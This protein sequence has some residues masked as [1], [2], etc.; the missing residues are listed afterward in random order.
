M[1]KTIM[2][3]GTVSGAGK[4]LVASGL[5]R[6]FRQDGYDAAPFQSSNAADNY[7]SYEAFSGSHDITVLEGAGSPSELHAG[8]EDPVNMGIAKYAGS[9]VLLV[10]DALR[11]GAFAQL[12]GTLALLDE[13]RRGRIKGLVI[14][15]LNEDAKV[16]K[17][18][19]ALLEKIAGRP[20]VGA[21]PYLDDETVK[22]AKADESPSPDQRPK[23]KKKAYDIAVIRFPNI[24]NSTDFTAL[25]TTESVELRYAEAE[26]DLGRPDMVILPGTK[27]TIRDLKWLRQNGLE[28]AIKSLAGEGAIVFGISGGYQMLGMEVRDAENIEGG[29]EIAGM[30]LLPISSDFFSVKIRMKAK[31]TVSGAKGC[32]GHLNG[33]AVE[34]YEIRTGTSQFIDGGLPLV[35]KDNGAGDGCSLGAT[36]GTY[37]HGFFDSPH[38]R[39]ALTKSLRE[40]AEEIEATGSN[41]AA[42]N[43]AQADRLAECVRANLDMGFIYKLLGIK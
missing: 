43:T 14:N 39:L 5:C 11:G 23:N 19:V 37:I 25:E 34:G 27:N 22:G 4:S 13:E 41:I 29:G 17:T 38:C 2:I 24:S 10:G 36:A 12:V 26:A 42:D 33:C 31:G 28:D 40:R 16:Y 20:V 7:K 18:G 9:P 1:K 30:G 32:L 15:K 8:K 6:V 3:Q 21:L 35:T